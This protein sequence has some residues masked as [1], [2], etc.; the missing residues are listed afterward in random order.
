[1]GMN[2]DP[3]HIAVDR[4]AL[5]ILKRFGHG[6]DQHNLALELIG[7]QRPVVGVEHLH[8]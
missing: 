3:G 4:S 6:A 8:E 2:L 5:A 7:N 1:M